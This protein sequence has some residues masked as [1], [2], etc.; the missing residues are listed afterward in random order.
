MF[1]N[2]LLVALRN[3]KKNKAF[4]FINILGL[5]IGMAAC[6]LIIQYV[7]FELSFDN[8]QA[9]KARIFR[10]DQDRYNNGKL[11]T[12][13]TAGA[14]A[15][16]NAIKVLPEVENV[17]KMVG[18]GDVLASYKDQ[19]MVIHNTYFA[20][21]DFFKVFS[22]PL[23][24]GDPKTALKEPNT[25][26]ISQE[27]ADKLFHGT[28][29]VGKSI[30][31]NNDSP[32]KVTGVMKKWPENTHMKCD[33]LLAYSTIYRFAGND[34]DT[35]WRNDGCITY[36]MLRP[37][38]NAKAVEKKF[39]AIANKA[40]EQFKADGDGA[41]YMLKPVQDI[42]LSPD[43]MGEMQA[44]AD[45]KSVYLLLG[46]AIF[47]IIIAWIN[48]INLAT[49][50]GVNRAKEVGVRKTLGSAKNQL[51]VQFM[52]E[53]GLLNLMSLL[54]AFI[55]IACFLPV[56]SSISGLHL[57]F[58]LFANSV[59]WLTVL[60]MLIVGTVFSGFYPALVLSSY[61]PVEVI[62][63]KLSA[64]QGGGL[65]RKALVVFQF[66]ASIFLLI[67]S[68]TVFR[69]VQFMQQQDLGMKIDQTVVI[70]AP[71]AKVDSFYR[72][73]RGF[74]QQC[75][76]RPDVK[77]VSVSTTIPGD[78]VFWNAGGI[79]LVGDD[80]K[81][82]KQYRVIG[83]DYDFLSAYNFKLLAGRLFGESF[84]TDTGSL[85]LSKAGAQ[86]LG[87][88]KPADVLGKRVFFWGKNYTVVGV[89]DNFH[90]QS[91]HDAYD[92]IIFRCIPDIRGSVSVKIS[93]TDVQRTI[94][95]LQTNWKTYFPGDEFN[96][97]FL[98]QHFN[99]Q[100][101]AD[102][103]FGQVF[104]IFTII[105]I[106]VACMGL[107]GLVSYTI[108]QRTKEI[109]IRKV[110]GASVNNILQLLYKDFAWLIVI[111]FGVSIPL[112]WYAIHQWLQSYPFRIDISLLLFIVP[113]VV[114]FIIAFV[115]VS[116][117]SMKAA[118]MNPVKSLK[119]E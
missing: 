1:K 23:I 79:K 111:A 113:F 65:L 110:L 64:S 100:Y 45:G 48:Y 101:K 7:T 35:R 93:S 38:A 73:M 107:F 60:A 17:V 94:Q 72:Q 88:N 87:F 31:V 102:Q 20:S 9:N 98:D 47:V 12:K 22:F 6:L 15:V 50:R 117:T 109:G 19:K 55:L 76:E 83:V 86:Q 13:W 69:Q 118:M 8:F 66:A 82:A 119:T 3:L 81:N 91:L 99:D 26:V 75:L 89:V 116:F 85:V 103:R 37:D 105:A 84:P 44:N 18:A 77:S 27:I 61:K 49:A 56:F 95:A 97:F 34:L 71:L 32:V 33:Y 108:V 54:L 46:I 53:A 80:D 40:Y 29:P 21:E 67:G 68:L 104:G 28:D 11:S 92:A 10:I 30:L 112:G 63:G 43:R 70:S 90:Q 25:V 115:T 24:S 78:P 51:V 106:L 62:K 58:T 4:S 14:F 16:G 114:V 2:Y 5:A 74:K 96:Y 39:A 42:H 36:V 57:S 59:F 52:F 41:V